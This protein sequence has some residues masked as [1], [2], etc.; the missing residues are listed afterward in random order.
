[1]DKLELELDLLEVI[2]TPVQ[3][4]RRNPWDFVP[5][6][7]LGWFRK[8]LKRPKPTKYEL[9]LVKGL[10]LRVIMYQMVEELET[11]TRETVYT[12]PL[13]HETPEAKKVNP[14]DLN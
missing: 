2:E 10:A 4:P 3:P 5:A 7:V 8:V 9:W 11:L 1:M 14:E 12:N 13:F 6:R